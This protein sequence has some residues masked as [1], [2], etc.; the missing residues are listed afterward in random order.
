MNNNQSILVLIALSTLISC[1]NAGKQNNAP[2]ARE[3]HAS[4]D[5]DCGVAD[6]TQPATIDYY[7]PSTGYSASYTLDVEIEDCQVVRIDFN[8][9]GYLDQEHIDPAD[10][11][12]NGDATVEDDRGR[13]FQV[14]IQNPTN[15]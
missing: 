14:H 12:E 5:E 7:N 15:E 9:G 1:R 2:E 13:S 11:D 3:S 8:N 4:Q 10:I 6:G